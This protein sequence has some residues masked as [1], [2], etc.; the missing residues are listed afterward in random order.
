[1]ARKRN[2]AACRSMLHQ[3]EEGITV[4]T[5]ECERNNKIQ[6]INQATSPISTLPDELIMEI[7]SRLPPRPFFRCRTVCKSW[8]SLSSEALG[9]NEHLRPTLCGIFYNNSCSGVGFV[10][11]SHGADKVELDRTVC[12]LSNYDILNIIDYCNGLLIIEALNK[13]APTVHNLYVYNPATRILLTMLSFSPPFDC[14]TFSL[15]FDPRVYSQFQIIRF[16]NGSDDGEISSSINIFSFKR[17]K[18]I[19]KK[20]LVC[21]TMIKF[22][23]KGTFV[24]GRLYR[25]T[26][27]GEILSINANEC[28]YQL[29]NPPDMTSRT[30]DKI[31]QSQG[32][33]HYI[34]LCDKKGL[35]F[36]W[37]LK[38]YTRQE[39][40]LK[41]Q[42]NLD[43][44]YS[45]LQPHWNVLTIY[46]RI[47]HLGHFAFHPEKD[48]LFMPVGLYDLM[49]FDMSTGKRKELINI[50]ENIAMGPWAYMPCYL[51]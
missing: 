42:L 35:M 3:E 23:S 14:R 10:N 31:G 47:L 50:G 12:A 43:K 17:G 30:F 16:S 19:S 1:M 36:I 11:L 20:E 39:W 18:C 6:R 41:Y 34:S 13:N 49:S 28:S 27:R 25:I 15:A 24:E 21:D 37:V 46:S 40:K 48:I 4:S 5:S 9:L 7:L 29:I 22:Y 2:M 26:T 8:L 51:V 38:S 45:V 33:L 44:I 32:L